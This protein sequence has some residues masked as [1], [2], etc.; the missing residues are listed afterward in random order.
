MPG[1]EED[2]SYLNSALSGFQ[3]GLKAKQTE[4]MQ[5]QQKSITCALQAS[6]TVPFADCL[7]NLLHHT[8]LC[9][10]INAQISNSWKHTSNPAEDH[11]ILCYLYQAT[12]NCPE[13]SG[14]P[15]H[16]PI[17]HPPKH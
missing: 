16:G 2:Y 17:S 3:T 11:K 9:N 4:S 12:V 5:Q 1:K 7:H 15:H 13:D 8:S 10:I 14:G 6:E